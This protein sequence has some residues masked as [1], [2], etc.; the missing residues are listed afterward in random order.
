MALAATRAA[1]ARATAWRGRP[2]GEGDGMAATMEVAAKEEV[3]RA[4]AA[5]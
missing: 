3:A 1:T 4:V 5:T 2:H